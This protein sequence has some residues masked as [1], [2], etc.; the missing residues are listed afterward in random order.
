MASGGHLGNQAAEHIGGS[1]SAFGCDVLPLLAPGTL[2]LS[3]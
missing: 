1:R 3:A 2:R